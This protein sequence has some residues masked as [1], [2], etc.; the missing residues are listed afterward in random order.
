MLV[1]D[2]SFS[3]PVGWP[4]CQLRDNGLP[5]SLTPRKCVKVNIPLSRHVGQFHDPGICQLYCVGPLNKV[6]MFIYYSYIRVDTW[7]FGWSYTPGTM[8]MNH[9]SC[10]HYSHETLFIPVS[11]TTIIIHSNTIIENPDNFH[12]ILTIHTG[13]IHYS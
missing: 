5:S 7:K 11:F 9:C 4:L 6:R 1:C 3:L 2:N 12:N 10:Q 8:H 13:T